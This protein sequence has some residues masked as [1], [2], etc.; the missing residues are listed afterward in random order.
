MADIRYGETSTAA[1]A[2][3]TA[4]ADCGFP[5]PMSA[6]AANDGVAFDG[7]ANHET[8]AAADAWCLSHGVD[9]NAQ[10]GRLPA[11]I[12]AKI[13]EAAPRAEPKAKAVRTKKKG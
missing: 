13:A 4:L 12:A 1:M 11:E 6:A 2:L 9:W 10:T 7:T 3:Q 8:W 5:L